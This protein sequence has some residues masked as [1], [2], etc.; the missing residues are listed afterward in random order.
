MNL[1]NTKQSQKYDR[2]PQFPH[3]ANKQ[4]IYILQIH[5]KKSINTMNQN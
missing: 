3:K 2:K 5:K 4:K 1:A